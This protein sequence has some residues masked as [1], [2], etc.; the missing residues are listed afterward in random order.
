MAKYLYGVSVQGIQEFIYKT[1]KLQE[2]IGASEIVDWLGREFDLDQTLQNTSKIYAI[3]D[4]FKKDG[5]VDQILLNA[6][7][8]FRAIVSGKDKLEKIVL[9]LPKDIMQNA[10]GITVS[11][12]A[13][14][15]K[16]NE[17]YKNVSY[18]LEKRLKIQRNK[19]SIPLDTSINLMLLSPK[20]ARATYKIEHEERI[21]ISSS[22]KREAHKVWFDKNRKN[23]DKFVELK[24]FSQISNSKNKI[25]IIHADGNG[26]GVLVKRL[27]DR[28]N[29]SN[30]DEITKFSKALDKAT[31]NVFKSAKEKI[32]EKDYKDSGKIKNII[33]SGDDMTAVCSADVALEFTKYFIQEFEKLTAQDSAIEGKLTMCAG[34]AYC[35]EKYPFHYAVELAEAL[36]SVAK[37]HSK[38]IYV[39]D[40]NKDIAPSCLMFHNIQ[41]S[42]FQSWDKFIIDELAVKNEDGFIRFDFGPYYINEKSQAKVD[43]LLALVKVYS[44]DDS[45]KTKLRGWLK[46]LAISGKYANNMLDRINEILGNK[47]DVFDVPL[48]SL[49]E[50]LSSSDLIIEKDGLIKTPIY[51]VL[52][53]LSVSGDIK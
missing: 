23:N 34:I 32:K 43:D 28:I 21:D 30:L 36:C 17:E 25:A 53:I 40:P 8:N 49:N 26:L 20:T 27:S 16:D 35:N 12:A 7:G 45:P 14:E 18:E 24:E 51:D 48:K 9:N 4:K 3:F 42:N 19:P 52:Q 44:G 6:A 5:L 46:E 1:N 38:N 11:Q 29:F 37:K 22:Q 13:V 2:I 41:S 50:K 33:L 10:Y 39:K 15:C 47:R 31:K